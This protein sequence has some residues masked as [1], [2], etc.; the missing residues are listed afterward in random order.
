MRQVAGR[1]GRLADLSS[2]GAHPIDGLAQLG[3][4]FTAKKRY[5]LR[6]WYATIYGLGV[7]SIS[8]PSPKRYAFRFWVATGN[9]VATQ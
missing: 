1:D 5:S 4:N 6:I 8:P 7:G 3:L 9:P 2:P